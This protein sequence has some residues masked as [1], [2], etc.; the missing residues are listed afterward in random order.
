MR[1]RKSLMDFHIFSYLRELGGFS[2]RSYL[3]ETWWILGLS[4][5]CA[6]G[7]LLERVFYPLEPGGIVA[8]LFASMLG[9]RWE[10]LFDIFRR[11]V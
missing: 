6:R 9:V 1:A 11:F 8:E 4:P 7:T 2:T 10:R 3:R 5:T